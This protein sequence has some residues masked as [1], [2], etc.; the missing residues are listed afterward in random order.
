MRTIS[1]LNKPIIIF[2]H[3]FI[4]LALSRPPLAHADL[5][6]K[7]MV[8]MARPRQLETCARERER[9]RERER[10][11][12]RDLSEECLDTFKTSLTCVHTRAHTPSD[13]HAGAVVGSQEFE[14]FSQDA[15][16]MKRPSIISGSHIP[17]Y[18]GKR[19]WGTL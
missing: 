3:F 13:T 16:C 9:K 19:L 18:A 10:E 7:S 17:E 1:E 12:E 15:A 4:S 8:C 14:R 11:R 2:C 6:V 5:R